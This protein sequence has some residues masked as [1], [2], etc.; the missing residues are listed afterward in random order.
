MAAA[1]GAASSS[2]GAGSA[3]ATRRARSGSSGEGGAPDAHAHAHS[4]RA[5]AAREGARRL[6]GGCGISGPSLTRESE[7][8]HRDSCAIRRCAALR[9]K[10]KRHD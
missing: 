3:A 4:K 2:P 10:E 8:K 6:L 1:V 9:A 5:R 7:A